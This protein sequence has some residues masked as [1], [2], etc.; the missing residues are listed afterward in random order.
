MSDLASPVTTLLEPLS[1]HE[2]R[3]PNCGLTRTE[4]SEQTAMLLRAAAETDDPD[5]A[6]ELRSRVVLINRGVAEAIARRYQGRGVPVDDLVQVAQEGLIKAVSRFDPDLRNDLLTFAVP[7]IR[8]EVQRYFRDQGWMVRPTRRVQEIQGQA[9]EATRE[10]EQSLGEEPTEQEVADQVGVPIAEYRRAVAAHGC[11][12]PVSLDLLVGSDRATLG[13]ILVGDDE[14]GPAS[15]ARLV[16]A[17]VVR[18]LSER[19]RRILYLRYFAD[20]TQTEIGKDLGVTQMQVSRLLTRILGD[21]RDEL[22]AA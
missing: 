8:G 21:L 15:E 5:D 12:Q 13:D 22:G 1:D 3:D 16:L 9:R 14:D 7:T 18:R 19:D 2:L 4:R 11:F 10:L 17:P 20:L 6:T